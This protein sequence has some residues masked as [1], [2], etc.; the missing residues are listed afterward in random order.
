MF[1]NF[2][3]KRAVIAGLVAT[4][5]M[6]GLMLAAPMMGM[7]RMNIGEMLG[8]M[9]G[10]VT[11]LGWMAHFMIGTTL[12]TA[13]AAFFAERLPGPSV[14]RGMLFGIAPWLLAQVVVMPMMGAG[15]F[16]GS[17]MAATGSLMGHLVYGAVLGTV[18]SRTD[19]AS[20]AQALHADA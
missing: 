2:N 6:T 13:Y 15:F 3:F 8:S 9:M 14:V 1:D 10:G 12:A 5:A 16:S 7:P 17:L 19:R 11:A 20:L 18:Y 4:T